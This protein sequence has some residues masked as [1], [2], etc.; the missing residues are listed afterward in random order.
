MSSYIQ[1]FF[2]SRDNHA[3]GNTYVGQQDRLWYNPDTNTIRISDGVTPGGHTIMLDIGAN[4]NINSLVANT[5]TINGNLIV[6][7]NISPA[8]AGKIG[9]IAPGPGVNISNAGILT[10]DTANLPFSFGDF[11]ANNNIMSIVNVGENMILATQG[12]ADIQLVGNVH[13]YKTGTVPPVEGTEFFEAAGDGRVTMYVPDP[14]SLNGAVKIVGSP[15]RTSVDPQNTGV[16]LHLTGQLADAS[17]IYNDGQAQYAAYIGRRYNTSSS[18]PSQVL[19][20]QIISRLGATPYTSNGWPVISTVRVDFVA[21]E[22][23]TASNNGARIEF[24]ATA[25]GATA[26]SKIATIDATGINITGNSTATGNINGNNITVSNNV[27][28]G[29]VIRYDIAQN[30]A[31]VTQLTSKTT[32]VTCN[33]RSGQITT[34]NSSIAKNEAVTFTVNNSYVTAGTDVPIV[35]LQSGATLNSYGVSTTRVQPGSFNI[36]ITNSGPA[37]LSDTIIINFAI[38]KVS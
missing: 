33:G 1:N 25:N 4:A 31:T 28:S 5:A 19:A 37:A 34:S 21:S 36:T 3:N 35:V 32:A 20:N 23:Q 6:V 27:V 24:W 17:R 15:D 8:A 11:Y 10:I 16:M 12:N 14:N 29:N 2:T 13:F 7:G 38:L 9:G 30:N 26:I 22:N 18:S